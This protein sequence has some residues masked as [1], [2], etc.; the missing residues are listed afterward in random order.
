MIVPAFVRLTLAIAA[1]LIG[2]VVLIFVLK[3]LVIAAIVAALVVGGALAV[4][5]IRRRFRP[6]AGPVVMTLTARR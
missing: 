3:V 1:I 4:R 6:A 2:F 5:I